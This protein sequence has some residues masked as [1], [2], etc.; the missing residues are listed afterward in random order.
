MSSLSLPS[1]TTSICEAHGVIA[2][3][4]K[5]CQELKVVIHPSS[6]L[7][8]GSPDRAHPNAGVL[9]YATIN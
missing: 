9:E 4:S 2:S 5:R 3:G 6:L 7:V 1:D 8:A